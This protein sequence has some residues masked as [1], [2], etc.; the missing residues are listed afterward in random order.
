MEIPLLDGALEGLFG[1]AT[2]FRATR[3]VGHGERAVSAQ[4]RVYVL[5]NAKP[6][7]PWKTIEQMFCKGTDLCPGW[8]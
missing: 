2:S 4:G 8:K 5:C 7:T 3:E 6:T 1:E